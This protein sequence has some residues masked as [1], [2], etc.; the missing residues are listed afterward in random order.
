MNPTFFLSHSTQDKRLVP[1]F[2]NLMRLGMNLRENEI[3]CTSENAIRSGTSYLDVIRDNFINSKIVILLISKKYMQSP[4]CLCEMGAA[5]ASGKAMIPLLV[6]VDYKDIEY[7][8]TPLKATQVSKLSNRDDLTNIFDDF[9]DY[10]VIE[11][12]TTSFNKQLELF[13]AKKLWLNPVGNNG[14]ALG[15]ASLA[16]NN[17]LDLSPPGLQS[18]RGLL[19]S[20]SNDLKKNTT[21]LQQN[22]L[23]PPK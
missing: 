18:T 23:F 16:N 15:L 9:R 4:F 1:E 17:S 2:M 12:S 8:T 6:N 11:A 14:S 7:P 21:R 20:P 13:M 22:F 3:F 19:R 5:W 10:K